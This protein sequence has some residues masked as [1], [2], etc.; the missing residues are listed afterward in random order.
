M[1][2]AFRRTLTF[3]LG[4]T[5]VFGAVRDVC[6][7]PL[8]FGIGLILMGVFTVPEAFEFIKGTFKKNGDDQQ[9]EVT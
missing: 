9:K 6:P 3:L 1:L 4:L 8:V 2:E 5:I 7:R